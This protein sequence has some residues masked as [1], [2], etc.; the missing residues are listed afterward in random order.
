MSSEQVLPAENIRPVSELRTKL[1]EIRECAK[2]APVVLSHNGKAELIIQDYESYQAQQEQLRDERLLREAEI[3][4]RACGNK[5]Y[6]LE[7]VKKSLA[8]DL[9]LA[10]EM[11]LGNAGA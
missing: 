6:S 10:Q 7:E 9:K 5:R 8:Q 2:K 3:W 1:S 11:G 4:D